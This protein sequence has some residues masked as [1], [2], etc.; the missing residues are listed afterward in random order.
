MKYL[1]IF[2]F[3]LLLLLYMSVTK[4]LN[5]LKVILKIEIFGTPVFFLNS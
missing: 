2:F 5:L 4:R 1:F 3:I